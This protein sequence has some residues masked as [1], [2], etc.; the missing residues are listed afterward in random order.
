MLKRIAIVV[1]ALATPVAAQEEQRARVS[2]LEAGAGWYQW[3]PFGVSDFIVFPSAPNATKRRYRRAV[4]AAGPR[5]GRGYTAP[6][7][8]ADPR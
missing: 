2:E 3:N 7:C 5:R 8:R 6:R 1:L 4:P